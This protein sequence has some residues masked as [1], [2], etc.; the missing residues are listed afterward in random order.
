MVRFVYKCDS[1]FL[2]R[3]D[4]SFDIKSFFLTQIISKHTLYELARTRPK[5]L[6]LTYNHLH[7]LKYIQLKESKIYKECLPTLLITL[8][9]HN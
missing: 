2:K 9:R 7:S 3:T 6:K 1:I 8:L 4:L 5:S